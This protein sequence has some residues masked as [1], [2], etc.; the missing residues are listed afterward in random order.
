MFGI[1]DPGI[2][3]AYAAAV[4]CLAFAVVF[5]IRQWNK[6]YDEPSDKKRP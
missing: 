3:L 6:E 4:A 2:Y 1:E 5:G